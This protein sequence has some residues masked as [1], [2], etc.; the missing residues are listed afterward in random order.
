[1]RF[2]G[3]MATLEPQKYVVR[4][5]WEENI[6]LVSGRLVEYSRVFER[7]TCRKEQDHCF[8]SKL[9]F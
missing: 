9:T 6:I 7:T 3:A 4:T 5:G 8:H 1:M 2:H